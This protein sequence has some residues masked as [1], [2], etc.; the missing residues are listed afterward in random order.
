METHYFQVH[1]ALSPRYSILWI[2]KRTNKSVQ[3]EIL[4]RRTSDQNGIQLDVSNKKDTLKISRD[5]PGGPVAK[6]PYS[7]CRGP[8][9]HCWSGN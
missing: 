5:F 8:M 6:T 7:Q 4:Q 9:Y 2:I 3:V 1:K